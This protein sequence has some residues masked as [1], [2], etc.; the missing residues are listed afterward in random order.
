MY[1]LLN[2]DQ[3]TMEEKIDSTKRRLE[4][5]DLELKRREREMEDANKTKGDL[6]NQIQAL[7][8]TVKGQFLPNNL[9]SSCF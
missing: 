1:L 8:S 4:T 7:K 2:R 6:Q 9:Q 3:S 5:L